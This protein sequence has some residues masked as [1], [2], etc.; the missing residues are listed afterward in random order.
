[1]TTDG[2]W[3]YHENYKCR[4]LAE[5]LSYFGLVDARITASEKDLLVHSLD[6]SVETWY[7]W[8]MILAPKVEKYLFCKKGKIVYT[9]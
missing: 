7:G 2:S 3:N 8:P 1:M 9:V 5:S 6:F 4:T